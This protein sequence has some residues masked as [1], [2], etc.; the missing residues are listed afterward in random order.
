MTSRGN[1]VNTITDALTGLYDRREANGIARTV[2]TDADGITF[3]QLIARP[4]EPSA[5]TDE[6]LAEITAQLAAGRPVQYVLGHCE[7]CGLDFEV[8]EGVLVP[9]PETEEVVAAVCERTPEGGRI[10][11]LCT[12]SGCIAIAA[13]KRIKNSRVTAIDLSARALCYARRNA[14]RLEADVEFIAGDVLAGAE[15]L[16]AGEFD[17]IVSN[18]PYVPQSDMATM[19]RNVVGYEP[20]EALFVADER[21]LIFYEAIADAG[22]TLLRKGGSLCFEV[23][24]LYAERVSAMLA[25]KGY[26][27]IEI[28]QDM[29][30]KP[31]TVCSRK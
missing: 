16:V 13:A 7:F 18:P 9:R 28:R 1:I 11:D 19:H 20:H 30:M 17:T 6:R 15:R 10:L 5:I 22:R 23:Y 8:G 25:A 24:E 12:G 21:P 4:E 14:E 2:V 29:N 31:R 3:S 27:D 26:R